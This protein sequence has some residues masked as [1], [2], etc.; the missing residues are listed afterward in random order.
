MGN[1]AFLRPKT[2]LEKLKFVFSG[3]TP[4]EH[5]ED[6]EQ[7]MIESDIDLE[8]VESLVTGL[9]TEKIPTFEAAKDF[10]KKI[11]IS[12]LGQDVC[13][14][15]NSQFPVII[16]LVGINGAGKTTTAGKLAALYKKTGKKVM[17]IAADTFR[18]AATEQLETWAARTDVDIIRGMDGA[19]PAAVVF[20]GLSAA[21]K[22][23]H[24]VIIADTAGRLHTKDNLMQ[25]LEKIKK[26]VTREMPGGRLEILLIVDAN[27]GKNAFAQAKQ[28]NESLGLTGVILTKF[29][30]TSKGGSVIKIKSD[31]NLPV[32]YYTFGEKIEDIE[33]FNAGKF[34]E[35]LFD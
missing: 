9:K 14:P 12:K 7:A 1:N 21:K 18:A 2:F 30:S 10:L 17:F 25:E 11:F 4:T 23:G 24:D 16:L 34:V 22:A 3:K 32:V 35:K 26:V 29:D 5:I 33:L 20:D 6:L 28:F 8:I 27:T 13:I 31:L 15:D 19:D